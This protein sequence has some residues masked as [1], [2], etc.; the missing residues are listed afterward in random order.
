M[1]GLSRTR[2]YRPDAA[3]FLFLDSGAS[4]KRNDTMGKIPDALREIIAWNIRDC[5]MRKF[6][7]RG[8]GKKCAEA[9]KVSPQQWSPWE[10][11]KRTPDET[12]LEQIA[13][14]FDTTVEYMRRDNRP[15]K[16]APPP[17]VDEPPKPQEQRLNGD[18]W[19]SWQQASINAAPSSV[20]PP[21][22][23]ESFFLLFR[24]LVDYLVTNG[25]KVRT[26]Q[27]P[28]NPYGQTPPSQ[29]QR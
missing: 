11:G 10:S 12:R 25:I 8:G 26:D 19:Q 27:A 15:T 28:Y 21:G 17:P 18:W 7:G 24:Y 2:G 3:L 22:S 23:P 14:F 29:Y 20:A 16:M 4:M 9:F 1:H 5:R 13:T 6:P